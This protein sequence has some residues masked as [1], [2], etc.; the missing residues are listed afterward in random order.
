[1]VV[2]LC[3]QLSNKDDKIRRNG[4]VVAF[5]PQYQANTQSE[6]AENG[7]V[8]Q[9]PPGNVTRDRERRRV[10][11]AYLLKI[12]DGP[13]AMTASVRFQQSVDTE[14]NWLGVAPCRTRI[15]DAF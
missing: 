12:M 2:A 5:L 8:W 11:L 9:G 3:Q 1:M 4:L 13:A 15:S 7:E 10:I 6:I 14:I